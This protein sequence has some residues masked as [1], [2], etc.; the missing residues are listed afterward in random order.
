MAGIY[1]MQEQMETGKTG[2]FFCEKYLESLSF[3]EKVIN[4]EENRNF[5]KK[6]IDILA[7][8][9][10]KKG[11]ALTSI[12]V[13][14]D[15]YKSGNMYVETISNKNKNTPGCILYSK[16][17]FLFYFFEKTKILYIMPMKK[18]REWFLLNKN[19]FTVKYPSTKNSF[20][21]IL[22][23]SEGYTV[24]LKFLERNFPYYKKVLL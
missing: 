21:K 23:E 7:K 19:H 20:G 15:T 12:E 6:D 16:A 1:S 24:P 14:C 4:V 8:I 13:K 18:F 5:Q 22:Y 3:V 17:D 9:N 11:K 10:T 2:I